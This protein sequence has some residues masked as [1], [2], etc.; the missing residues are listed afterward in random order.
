MAVVADSQAGVTEWLCRDAR[1][2][3]AQR[4]QIM[5]WLDYSVPRRVYWI[6]RRTDQRRVTQEPLW[7]S[8]LR[9]QPLRT[10]F[11]DQGHI[12]RWAWRTRRSLDQLPQL[13]DRQHP[14]VT[15][16]RFRPPTQTQR[17]LEDLETQNIHDPMSRKG[18]VY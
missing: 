9:E 8:E 6:T 12:V 16:Y 18:M 15:L 4:V 5:N 13:L 14:H 11:I 2:I 1:A 3:L 10:I 7:E 17:W